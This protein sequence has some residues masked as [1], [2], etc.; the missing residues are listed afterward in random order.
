M[1][2]NIC[3]I[4]ELET[5]FSTKSSVSIKDLKNKKNII[6]TNDSECY[7]SF[8]IDLPQCEQFLIE[9]SLGII[10]PLSKKIVTISNCCKNEAG[11]VVNQLM[12]VYT[13]YVTECAD[14]ISFWTAAEDENTR[15]HYLTIMFPEDEDSGIENSIYDSN[16]INVS[17]NSLSTIS[18]DNNTSSR[19][20]SESSMEDFFCEP[21]TPVILYHYDK[22]YTIDKTILQSKSKKFDRIFEKENEISSFK[23]PRPFVSEHVDEMINYLTF[24][25]CNFSTTNIYGVLRLAFYY[26]I[27]ELVMDGEN[28]VEANFDYLN[29]PILYHFLT[30]FSRDNLISSL[31]EYVKSNFENL[32]CNDLFMEYDFVFFSKIFCEIILPDVNI[33]RG[34]IMFMEWINYDYVRRLSY[35]KWLV[36]LDEMRFLS[37]NFIMNMGTTYFHFMSNIDFNIHY[38]ILLTKACGCLE[39]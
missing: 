29:L 19:T 6:L 2:S 5:S 8:R 34:V 7:A 12:T 4:G 13:K 28:W 31:L 16:N 20:I 38:V 18:F 33:N 27:E 17:M 32:F 11:G 15:K 9:P 37:K 39:E 22:C 21:L 26:E 35:F 30:E 36:S 14:C 24:N 10:P 1:T 23:I 25:F 3:N